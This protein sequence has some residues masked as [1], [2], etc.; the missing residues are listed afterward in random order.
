MPPFVLQGIMK[1]LNGGQNCGDI[2]FPDA[3][4]VADR[5]LM[6]GGL[7]VEEGQSCEIPLAPGC[8]DPEAPNYDPLAN[9][10][11]DSCAIVATPNNTFSR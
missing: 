3:L 1:E 8:T 4:Y 6:P 9:V 5:C 2:I 10:D 11:D 7:V